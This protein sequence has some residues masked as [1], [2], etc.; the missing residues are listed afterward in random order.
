MRLRSKR[1]ATSVSGSRAVP[2]PSGR[3]PP[4][5]P[6]PPQPPVRLIR[7]RHTSVMSGLIVQQTRLNQKW[8][9]VLFM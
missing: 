3:R 8:V 2:D 9:Y 4:A 7:R 5:K 1:N 6:P